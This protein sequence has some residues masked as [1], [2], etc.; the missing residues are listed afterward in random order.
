[1]SWTDGYVDEINYICGYR[2][3]FAPLNL[4]IAVLYQSRQ[5]RRSGPLRYLELG[6]G[7]GLSLNIHAAAV[8]G[9]YWGVDFNPAHVAHARELAEAS[10]ADVH[11]FENSFAELAERP[12]LPEFDVIVLHG[13]WSWISE[14]NRKIITDIIRRKLVPGGILFVSY[15]TMPGWA[16]LL[17]LRQLFQLHAELADKTAS[18]IAGRIDGALAFARSL[19]EAG[20]GYFQTQPRSAE[21]LNMMEG[22]DRAYLAHEYF[23]ADWHPMT[24]A[25]VAREL[26]DSKVSFV[27]SAYLLDHWDLL[28]FNNE[29]QA[30]LSKIS[31]PILR[32]TVQDYCT[33]R[34]FRRDVWVKGPRDLTKSEQID[35][36]KAMSFVLVVHTDNVSLSAR[37]ACVQANLPPEQYG[38]VIQVL[39][40]N[41]YAP[42]TLREISAALPYLDISFLIQ[43]MTIFIG[44]GQVSPAQGPAEAAAAKPRTDA[45]NDLLIKRAVCGR[46]VDFLAS[47]VTG[48]GIAVSRPEQLLLW[49]IRLGLKAP[50]EWAAHVGQTLQAQGEVVGP[51]SNEFIAG[52]LSQAKE[53]SGNRLTILRA[54]KI[55]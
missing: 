14:A 41:D 8:G 34:Q 36:F 30:I 40:A 17:P 15:N 49:A 5:V 54:L 43:A 21:W 52:L 3:E 12:D 32:E 31:N 13:I 45:L 2:G 24:F 28:N 10:G 26:A 23:N 51:A 7:Q 11:L 55:A 50:E 22:Q 29:Q 42:K 53:F 47:P 16:G 44:I 1:M 9:C 6:F 39:A 27:A 25:D 33:N 37:G 19:N 35:C 4:D 48:T 18:G 46:Q 20:A 38:P